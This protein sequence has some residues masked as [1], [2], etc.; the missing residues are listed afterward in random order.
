MGPLDL[1]IAGATSN[2]AGVLLG[3][4]LGGDLF[5]DI[6]PTD[7]ILARAL[8]PEL[9]QP[10]AAA[11]SLYQAA[12]RNLSAFFLGIF[13]LAVFFALAGWATSIAASLVR[14]FD[15]NLEGH[16]GELRVSYGMFTRREKGFRRSRV[17]NVQVEESIL[18]R[19][20]GLAALTVQTAGYGPSVK[21]DER[22]ETLTPIARRSEIPDYLKAVYP[23]FDWEGVEWRPSHPRARRR[24]F[25][26]R[27]L[28]VLAVT[29]ALTILL[30]PAWLVLSLGLIPAWLLAAAHYRHLG[31]ARL[32]PYLLVR[33]GLWTRRTHIIPVK[34]IQALH[35]RQSPFQR[36]L[37]L[38]TLSIETA[39]HPFDLHPPRTID[40][41]VGYSRSIMDGL[42]AEVT[43]TGLTF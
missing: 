42:V 38:G 8:P 33:E 2:R 12:Q 4:L 40:L 37:G 35:L 21:A 31:H 19:W 18:R 30:D 10:D 41:G 43:A 26:R 23:D 16:A 17:Q 36:Y 39:G 15:F 22:V 28:V 29:I 25:M 3:A 20:L 1:I 24:L 34:K 14:Y 27:A 13:M 11:Q 32:G 6:L 5:L 7:W 9:M